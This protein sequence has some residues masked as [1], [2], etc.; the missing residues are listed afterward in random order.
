MKQHWIKLTTVLMVGPAMLS[1][2]IIRTRPAYYGTTVT[3]PNVV[4]AGGGN[5]IAGGGYASM[6]QIGGSQ[7][8]FGYVTMGPGFTPDPVSVNVVSGGAMNARNMGLPGGCIGWVT[9]TPDYIVRFTGSTQRLRFFVTGST[10]TTLVI[11]AA[12]GQW[13]CNDDSYGSTNPTVDIFGAGPGQ[14]DVW[15]GSYRQ[16]QQAQA[17]LHMTELDYHP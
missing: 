5:V 3:S 15:V 7:A 2:C 17:Q 10:D 8:N 1:G 9:R 6:L 13:A 11:N 12:N 4:V 14:Y 16:G